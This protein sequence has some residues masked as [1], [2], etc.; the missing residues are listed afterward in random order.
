L[1]RKALLAFAN[2][3]MLLLHVAGE[4]RFAHALLRDH[5]AACDPAELGAAV[6]RR[7]E[8]LAAV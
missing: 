3:R 2:D 6:A 1:R 5:I 4:Y 8:E 7:R